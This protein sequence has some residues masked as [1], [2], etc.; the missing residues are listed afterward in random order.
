MASNGLLKN[1]INYFTIDQHFAIALIIRI[2]LIFYSLVHDELFQ[3]KYTDVDYSVFTDGSRYLW[4]G[5]SPFFR[6]GY[7]YTPIFAY[8]TLLNITFW[9]GTGK[10]IFA[11]FDVLTGYLIY[12]LIRELKVKEEHN[13]YATCLW[14]YN[15]LPL[16]VSTRGS[17][18]SFVTFLILATLLLIVHRRYFFSGCLFGLVCHCKIYPIIYAP[19]LYFYLSGEDAKSVLE[20]KVILP[21]RK[22]KIEFVFASALTF[23]VVTYVCYLK[24]GQLYIEEAWIYHFIRR[25]YAHNFSPYFYLYQLSSNRIYIK[26]LGYLAF[27]PQLMSILHFS[28]KYTLDSPDKQ[29]KLQNLIFS[30]FCTTFLF[31][32][33][34][35][36]CTSQYFLWYLA[37]L[38]LSAPYLQINSSQALRL[39]CYWLGSQGIWLFFAYCYEFLK[40]DLLF[41]VWLSSIQFLLVNLYIIRTLVHNFKASDAIK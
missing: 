19:A 25:D 39:L 33:L 26:L 31:V 8:M 10:L 7:R 23:L 35:K 14:L 38:P 4:Q 20:F 1:L 12:K 17:S 3:L 27:L 15:P 30:F 29:F 36:V 16:L 6:F 40:L 24:F 13:K 22:K 28:V 2:L 37:L 41:L 18:D 9:K 34:N 11:L 5:R 21:I 32:T